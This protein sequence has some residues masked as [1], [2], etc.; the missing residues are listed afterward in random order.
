[1]LRTC[2]DTFRIVS[3]HG[4]PR[5]FRRGGSHGFFN[6][7]QAQPVTFLASVADAHQHSEAK[8]A[9][10][11]ATFSPVRGIHDCDR[12]I[13]GTGAEAGHQAA[14]VRTRKEP[15]DRG[16]FRSREWPKRFAMRYIRR[17]T[18][19]SFISEESP[20]TIHRTPHDEPNGGRPRTALVATTRRKCAAIPR[21]DRFEHAGRGDTR[22]IG[23]PDRSRERQRK[24]NQVVRRIADDG[25]VEVPDLYFDPAVGVRHRAEIANVTVSADPDR[26]TFWDHFHAGLR[27]P[28]IKLNGRAAHK[29][30][31][32][33]RHFQ[34]LC[35]QQHCLA[36]RDG[37]RAVTALRLQ[38]LRAAVCTGFSARPVRS[39]FNRRSWSDPSTDFISSGCR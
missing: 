30:V 21:D 36:P 7:D 19:D 28:L 38:D 15:M 12:R 27:E 29:C 25:L 26:W 17:D 14:H 32:G 23:A 20:G 13:V 16:A 1:M 9:E 4:D 10:R 8:A 31:D 37:R 33:A 2:D 6:V 22:Q 3:L 39:L 18:A 34:S 5:C 24:A 35:R 11:T